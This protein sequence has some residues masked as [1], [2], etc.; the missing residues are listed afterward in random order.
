MISQVIITFFGWLAL[1]LV[2]INLVGMLVRGLV[3]NPEIDRMATEGHDF[4]KKLAKEHQEAEKKV[5]FV[6]LILIIVYLAALF[7][8]WNIGVVIA[9]LMIMLAR[10]P[11]LLWE[12]KHGRAKIKDMPAIYMLTFLIMLAALPV[13][14]YALYQL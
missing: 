8:F 12:M 3:S 9:A 5:N 4:V 7:Y 11:D 1:V 14:W 10:I 2:S 13:L 6:A